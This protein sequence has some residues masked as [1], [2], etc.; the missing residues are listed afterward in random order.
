MYK[1]TEID[2]LSIKITASTTEAEAAIDRLATKMNSLTT[3]YGGQGNKANNATQNLNK[4]LNSTNKT[5]KR[6]K[7]SWGGLASVIG[8]FYASCFLAIRGV[9]TLGASI[10][11]TADYFEAFNY[12]N[13]ALG[14]IGSDWED[15]FSKYGYNSAEAYAESFST[16]LQEKLQGLSGLQMTDSGTLDTTGVKNLGLNIQEITQFSAQLA[17]VTNSVGQV[18]EVSLATSSA[19][20]KLA[21]DMSSL[22]NMDYSQVANN[23]QSGLIGQSRAL[24][25]YGID[26]TNATLQT[27][28]YELGIE[29]A[30]SE[31][32]QAEK[33]Q[34]RIIAIL[35]QSRVAWTDQSRTI[36]SLSNQMR[37]LEN[38]MQEIS[39]VLGQLFVPLMEKALPIVNGLTRA[40]KN[41]LVNLAGILGI[42]IDPNKFGQGFTEIEDNFEG[43]TEGTEEAEKAL[44]EYKNQLLG[45]DEVNK[46]QDVDAKATLDTEQTG[47]IDLTEE[48]LAA[49]EEY[50]KFWQEAFANMEDYSA[51]WEEYFSEFAEPI[52]KIFTDIALGDWFS[53]GQDVSGTAKSLTED[54]TK[55]LKKIEWDE[56]GSNAGQFFGGAVS[57]AFSGLGSGTALV[58][59]V[60]NSIKEFLWNAVRNIDYKAIAVSILSGIGSSLSATATGIYEF[61]FGEVPENEYAI[62]EQ[63]KD[64]YEEALEYHDD[65]QEK[66]SSFKIDISNQSSEFAYIEGLKNRYFELANQTH[67]TAEEEANMKAYRQEL[68]DSSDEIAKILENETLTYEEQASAIEDVIAAMKKKTTMAAAQKYLEEIESERLELSKTI[69]DYQ[70]N[71]MATAYNNQRIASDNLARAETRLKNAQLDMQNAVDN[72]AYIQASIA[73]GK[74]ETEVLAAKAALNKADTEVKLVENTLQTHQD[75]MNDL[76]SE[77]NWYLDVASG[78]KTVESQIATE[79]KKLSNENKNA[80]SSF[81]SLNQAA[82]SASDSMKG[83]FAKQDWSGIGEKISSGIA[84]GIGTGLE[85][86]TAK[87]WEKGITN[88]NDIIT[89]GIAGKKQFDF[90]LEID[91][92]S[93]EGYINIK[94]KWGMHAYANGGFPED[95]LF[96]A[97]HNELVG[98]FSNG[99]TAV[100]NNGQI[101]EGIKAGVYDAVTSAI[102]STGSNGSNVT[103]VLQ[104]D[105]DGLF[106]VVQSKADNYTMQTGRPA[107]II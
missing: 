47:G 61:L 25:K 41:L 14:K 3:S 66:L 102:M 2:S 29:K 50:E 17:S 40:I 69:A 10:Q 56:L 71:E 58:F 79:T 15:D 74:Y 23:L 19:F 8:R 44:E 12:F 86:V 65:I 32:T 28:A 105:A 72:E 80:S 4:N 27:Y 57:T 73:V 67:R 94:N 99:K 93:L 7:T 83:Q 107:F 76:T 90:D 42:K 36:N 26:I 33:M 95:G 81:Q 1:L 11:S 13:V 24:Y 30:V 55:I 49:T 38:N 103:V 77:Y 91:P 62:S 46:L 106:K 89:K 18:G 92:N 52:E 68:V 43:I 87:Q 75:T 85:T 59:K 6:A 97:N 53:L 101:V 64:D 60:G 35:N 51:Q 100:A 16:R 84:H 37:I 70:E 88:I 21:S 63:L 9:K 20:T 31:M 54:L 22:F 78:V 82:K 104:G 48:I 5:V 96:F 45:F 39:L 98:K 34:L